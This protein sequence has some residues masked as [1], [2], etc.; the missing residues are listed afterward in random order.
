MPHGVLVFD[1][2]DTGRI[3]QQGRILEPEGA[4]LFKAVDMAQRRPPVLEER[5]APFDCLYDARTR[6][7]NEFTQVFKNGPGKVGRTLDIDV[8]AG[9]G[10]SHTIKYYYP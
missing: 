3:F 10:G 8:D 1:V 7:V 9:I 5:P 4:M 6:L 2:K